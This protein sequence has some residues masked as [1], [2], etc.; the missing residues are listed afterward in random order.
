MDKLRLDQ[1]YAKYFCAK[2]RKQKLEESEIVFGEL[3]EF[4]KENNLDNVYPWI[5]NSKAWLAF[6]QC[7]Y[8]KA[9][10]LHKETYILF[11]EKND[12]FGCISAYNGLMCGYNMKKELDKAIEYGILAIKLAE[13]V[14]AYEEMSLIKANVAEIYRYIGEVKKARE[15]LEEINNLSSITDSYMKEIVY[16]NTAL[17]D[18]DLG[19]L[20]GAVEYA[21]KA[22]ERAIRNNNN[23]NISDS[24]IIIS[25]VYIKQGKYDLA[26]NMLIDSLNYEKQ[27]EISL[28]HELRSIAWAE[29]YIKKEKFKEAITILE[30]IID[31]IKKTNVIIYLTMVYS[32]LNESYER[33]GDINK[34]YYYHKK[35]F[36]IEKEVYDIK[37]SVKTKDL[38]IIKANAAAE[39]YKLLFNKNEALY[40]IGKRIIA[41][42]NNDYMFELIAKE[43]KLV[44][45]YSIIDV[46]IFNDNKQIVHHKLSSNDEYSISTK[47]ISIVD[48]S[49][50][51]Y[52]IR[53]RQALLLTDVEKEKSAYI[54]NIENYLENNLEELVKSAMFVP[55]IVKDDILGVI[56]VKSFKKNAYKLSDITTL[57]ILST[58]LGI[59]V[60][61][62]RL[63]KEVEYAASFD[64][65][66]N[67]Y[68]RRELFRRSF[69]VVKRAESVCVIM[70]DVDNFKMIND[71]FGHQI[72]D[73][74]L[75]EIARKIKSSL[76]SKDI[77]GRYGGEEFMVILQ[78]KDT[79]SCRIIAERI[80]EA[81]ANMEIKVKEDLI[82][83]TTISIGISNVLA[84]TNPLKQIIS[85]ADKALYH[86]K[87]TGKNKVVIYGS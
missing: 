55:I 27:R 63:Y 4:V 48:D 82:I 3:I 23:G 39:T 53:N 70:T 49:F 45:N 79:E 87:N 73:K 65:L 64:I 15:I 71:K 77:L 33:L 26:E 46:S 13:S 6:D 28:P 72:G 47:E 1:G 86:A 19:N 61:N 2:V 76:R 38:E 81:V 31:N 51:G 62:S 42:L 8:L 85:Y 75:Q 17:C 69:E 36:N 56:S 60:V 25:R 66:T 5:L 12:K 84:I 22:Y 74:V 20:H 7:D 41:N 32:Y 21:K 78:N 54:E 43:I 57:K 30:M 14:G 35:L 67:I 83:K 59:A 68:N 58:Y 52:C 80:R 18:F 37:S 44:I 24:M 29:L 11:N 50:E 16:L 40:E 10:E 34:A 9:I